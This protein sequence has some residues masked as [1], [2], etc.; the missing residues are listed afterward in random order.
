MCVKFLG[1]KQTHFDNTHFFIMK[2]IDALWGKNEEMAKSGH[3]YLAILIKFLHS[4][5]NT[6]EYDLLLASLGKKG[7]QPKMQ[8]NYQSLNQIECTFI[9]KKKNAL[10]NTAQNLFNSFVIS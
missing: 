8:S 9:F 2:T 10:K 5:L 6:F 4:F 1:T 7:R 3:R